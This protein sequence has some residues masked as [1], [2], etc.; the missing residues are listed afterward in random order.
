MVLF[1]SGGCKTERSGDDDDIDIGGSGSQKSFGGGGESG[2]GGHDII[3]Q[4]QMFAADGIGVGVKGIFHGGMPFGTVEG[5]LM[6]HG[7]AFFQRGCDG[8]IAFF[9]DDFC[10]Q[11]GLVVT[12]LERTDKIQRYGDD[13]VV[14]TV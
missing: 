4:E 13:E 7:E 3:D 9:A 8:D 14:V 1:Q 10:Q 2:T 12:A 11:S 5:G 6:V